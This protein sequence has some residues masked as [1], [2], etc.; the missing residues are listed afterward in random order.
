MTN[1]SYINVDHIYCDVPD[2]ITTARLS[3]RKPEMR[4]APAFARGISDI[5]VVR[6]TASF[7]PYVPALSAEFWIYRARAN[8]ERGIAFP[9]LI[10]HTQ[11]GELCGVMDI[12]TNGS[13][14]HEIG[15]W[16]ARGSWGLGYATEAGRAV[17]DT[18]VPLLDLRQI[19]GG[20]YYDNPG[21]FR[22][23]EKLGF[24]HI[25]DTQPLFSLARGR[26]DSG[27]LYIWTAP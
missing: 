10:T 16:I 2:L 20:V 9:Y 17:I 4:Y 26:A 11:S 6:N 22:V 25:D 3:L 13:G 19:E 1:Q 5:A 12:F 7:P 21:S 14:G 27:R 18:I 8:F 24:K 15:Y 23:L